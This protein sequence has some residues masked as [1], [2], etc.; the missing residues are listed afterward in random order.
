MGRRTDVRRDLGKGT[1]EAVEAPRVGGR[2]EVAARAR[3]RSHRGADRARLAAAR[4]DRRGK[5]ALPSRVDAIERSCIEIRCAIRCADRERT[6]VSRRV[7]YPPPIA[8]L[9]TSTRRL[10]ALP[11][12]PNRRARIVLA[13]HAASRPGCASRAIRARSKRRRP[14]LEDRTDAEG[15][16]T[17]PRFHG[18]FAPQEKREPDSSLREL[19]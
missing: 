4:T 1:C 17:T 15:A 19:A 11:T 8:R 18:L 14:S 9:R 13:P 5:A 2:N 6:L 12:E 3:G 10:W 7:K 16:P